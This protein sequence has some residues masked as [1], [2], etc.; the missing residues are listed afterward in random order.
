[1]INN[2]NTNIMTQNAHDFNGYKLSNEKKSSK[3]H[4]NGNN[5]LEYSIP[6][7]SSGN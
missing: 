3:G 6:R 4:N 5:L 2:L 1:M 7:W